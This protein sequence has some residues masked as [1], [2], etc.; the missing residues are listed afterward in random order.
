MLSR[1][2]LNPKVVKMSDHAVSLHERVAK[3]E[4]SSASAHKRLDNLDARVERMHQMHNEVENLGLEMKTTLGIVAKQL[5][6]ISLTIGKLTDDVKNVEAF[7]HGWKGSYV[8][9]IVLG[10]VIATIAGVL[11]IIGLS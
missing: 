11:S 9:L 8:A 2:M 10:S 5:E 1:N 3:L 7:R 4:S 6:T